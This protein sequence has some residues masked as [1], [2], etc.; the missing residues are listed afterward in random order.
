MAPPAPAARPLHVERKPVTVLSC[1]VTNL[2]SQPWHDDPVARSA[3]LSA[4]WSTALRVVE[5][6]GGTVDTMGDD[7]FVA[8][9]GVP[10]AYEDHA[11]R[12]LLVAHRLPQALQQAAETRLTALS[13]GMGIHSGTVIAWYVGND[14]RVSPAEAENAV[15]L[16]CRLQQ[17]AAP[18]C[19]L[20]SE[21]TR[22]LLRDAMPLQKQGMLQVAGHDE[23]LAVYTILTEPTGAEA[24]SL[25][26]RPRCFVGR[27]RELALLHERFCQAQAGQGQVVALVG[28]AGIGKS[29][30]LAEFH[31]RVSAECCT[32]LEGYGL[33]YGITQP[34]G[35][36]RALLWQACG[37]SPAE[38]ADTLIAKLRRRLRSLALDTEQAVAVCLRLL[39]LSPAADGLET[40][41]PAALQARFL[42]VLGQLWVRLSEERP[43]VVVLENLHWIDQASQAW[44]AAL[45]ERVAGAAILLLLTYRPGYHAPWL[46]K[47]Y[48]TQIALRPLGSAESL[49]LVHAIVPPVRLPASVAQQILQRAEGHP[50]FLEELARAAAEQGLESGTFTVPATIQDVI[51]A[52]LDQLP[53]AAK[54]LLQTASVLG[55]RFSQGLLE[56]LWEEPEGVGPLLGELQRH[57][58]L[59]EQREAGESLHVFKHALIQEV[60]YH[61]LPLARRQALHAAAG[62]ALERRH[63]GRLEAVYAQ[64]AYHYARTEVAA[65][66]VEYLHVV[67]K[68]A[69]RSHAHHEA[70]AA[71][72]EAAEHA[73]RLSPPE[74]D[75]CLVTLALAEA[76]SLS[77]LGRFRE[78][79]ACLQRHH[80]RIERLQEAALT[81]PYYFRLGLTALYLGE[82]AQVVPYAQRALAAARRVQDRV[83]LGQAYYCLALHY[84]LSGDFAQ[85]MAYGRQAIAALQETGEQHWLGLAYWVL[86]YSAALLG[87]VKAALDA[88]AQAHAIGVATEDRRLQSFADGVRG[89]VLAL[90]GATQESLAACRRGYA[91]AA[92]PVSKGPGGRLPGL[93]L[94]GSW[95]SRVGAAVAAR[96][97]DPFHQPAVC[98]GPSS[99]HAF[100]C[101]GPSPGGG[102]GRSARVGTPRHGRVAQR[103]ILARHRLGSP[104]AWPPRATAGAICRGCPPL[105]GSPGDFYGAAGAL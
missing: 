15:A 4:F 82:V 97:G 77:V 39:D 75:H 76:F 51:M 99:L 74:R 66:A 78:V 72:R 33:S 27:A 81:G 48:V 6:Y 62:A 59:Y 30:L 90:C 86:G 21:A 14:V 3:V 41:T 87:E 2:T 10:V 24:P 35:P 89:W 85:G 26:P 63:A 13:L 42:E 83:T 11:W 31:R 101:P 52:R 20:L 5:Q 104:G 22:R 60:S 18:R 73:A 61:S 103:G 37:L 102:G 17:V 71:L 57:E 105:S 23:P 34:Y 12:A 80:E 69:L 68:K 53:P 94:P 46:T 84:Y 38:G 47:S 29:C 91:H 92:D 100:S 67:A 56:A 44:L 65:K 19:L 88:Q 43:L 58:M 40:L 50:F 79:Q 7:S 28:E 64:L 32:F 36:V 70:L 25:G 54:R 45:V 1:R 9:F 98:P 8:L 96:G 95:G 49:A 16:A 93:C 55:R